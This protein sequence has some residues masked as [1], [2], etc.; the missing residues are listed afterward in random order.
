MHPR[1]QRNVIRPSLPRLGTGIG[2]DRATRLHYTVNESLLGVKRAWLARHHRGPTALQGDELQRDNLAVIL[3]TAVALT[4]PGVVVSGV[5]RDAVSIIPATLKLRLLAQG[6][7]F[8]SDLA[9]IAKR[10][11][12]EHQDLQE[13][14]FAVLDRFAAVVAQTATTDETLLTP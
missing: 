5:W 1:A 14:D 12:D 9:T 13:D 4:D 11:A 7:N 8:V 10:L 3:G 6:P 2:E